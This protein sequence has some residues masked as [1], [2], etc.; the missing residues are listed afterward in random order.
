MEEER[1]LD[2][3]GSRNV[4]ETGGGSNPIQDGGGGGRSD[5]DKS[6]KRYRV[7]LA[8]TYISLFVGS[9]SSSML[10]RFYFVHGGSSRWVSTWVQSAGFPLLLLPIY[11]PRLFKSNITDD[12]A[13]RRPP[14]SLFTRKLLLISV[15]MGLI[16]AISNFL[17]SWGISYLSL[18]TSSLLLSTQL[19]FNLILSVLLVK[20][21]I[22]FSNVNAV[23]LLTLSSILL[24]LGSSNDRP[25][26]V[27]KSHYYLGFLAILSTSML[28]ALY[29]PLME[30]VYRRVRC[31]DMVIE[32]QLIMGAVA[33]ALASLGMALDGGYRDIW[34]ESKTSF[35]LG[36]VAYC[37]T[38]GFNVVT[39]QLSFMGSAGL[40][41]LTT[42]LTSGICMTALLSMNVLGGVL[43]FG[44]EFG[45]GKV[46]ST[47]LCVWGFCSYVFGEY[48]KIVKEREKRNQEMELVGV[49]TTAAG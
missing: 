49:A 18:S 42:S 19:A 36:Q 13:Y 28:F 45:G 26:G 2:P 25:K 48:R 22:T 17:Y 7:L 1:Q 10:S 15:L 43:A 46:V 38:V 30:M 11:L 47:L 39:W 16:I 44:D 32:M 21:R 29:L 31:Y 14:F 40:V 4:D 23:I 5:K 8:I 35:D 33:T 3:S 20:Q 9:I 37:L 6:S 34:K 27:T 24:A 41:Y 12:D